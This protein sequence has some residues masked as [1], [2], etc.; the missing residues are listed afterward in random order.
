MEIRRLS[1]KD[2]FFYL[3]IKN[4]SRYAKR[5]QTAYLPL[6]CQKET[7]T[8]GSMGERSKPAHC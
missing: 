8:L 2:L 4:N 7:K 6:Q 5:L 3:A 1:L